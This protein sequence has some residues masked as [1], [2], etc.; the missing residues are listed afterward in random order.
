MKF[1]LPIL[2]FFL[3]L[4][5]GFSQTEYKISTEG[6]T[7]EKPVGN[8][9]ILKIYLSVANIG[10]LEEFPGEVKK[11]K[12]KSSNYNFDKDI[13]FV[14]YKKIIGN[15]E[16]LTNFSV[17]V[18]SFLVP[19][20]AS[21][22]K[23][24]FPERYGGLAIDVT[25]KNYNEWAV[26]NSPEN[27]SRREKSKTLLPSFTREVGV[28][29]SIEG[30]IINNSTS[31]S[32][33]LSTG[34]LSFELLPRFHEFGKENRS[35]L[36][37]A[38]NFSFS[39]GGITKG[40][41]AK[42]NDFY[43]PDTSKYKIVDKE[44]SDSSNI[45]FYSA[46]IGVGALFYFGKINPVV[47]ISYIYTSIIPYKL[48][49]KNISNNTYSDM[50]SSNGSGLK[51]DAGFQF[52]NSLLIGYTFRYFKPGGDYSFVNKQHEIHTLRIAIWGWGN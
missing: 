40:N 45:G 50:A 49:V 27:T 36:F 14:D 23:I 6:F 19:L 41:A 17:Y 46:G 33:S 42:L 34:N 9:V 4:K 22:I 15:G 28:G 7:F 31:G 10:A 35:Q 8:T 5:S 37:A 3:F 25:K 12:L 32:Q 47:T 1:I 30:G 51:I 13:F 11:I 20:D 43:K 48:L 38:I 44:K 16:N 2:L 24:V 52:F 18:L 26:S 21:N 39:V 29:F